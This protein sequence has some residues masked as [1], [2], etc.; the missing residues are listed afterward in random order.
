MPLSLHGRHLKKVSLEL[1]GK[2]ALILLEDADLDVAV[3]NAA[4]G[5][6]FHQGQAH[7]SCLTFNLSTT[8]K[9]ERSRRSA[10]HF[11]LAAFASSITVSARMYDCAALRFQCRRGTCNGHSSA[12]RHWA[13]QSG[14]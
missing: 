11:C 14:V 7:L 6:W 8:R 10:M 2:N 5:A 3:S 4:F 12:R 13:R 9:C 1:G